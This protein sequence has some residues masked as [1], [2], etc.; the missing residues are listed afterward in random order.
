MDQNKFRRHLAEATKQLID[1][2]QSLC[3]ND[4]SDAFRYTI[5]PSS[6][7]LKKDVEHLNEFEISVLKTWNKY[8]NQS[9]TAYQTVELLHHK[10]KVPLWIDMSVYEANSDLTI[11]DLFCS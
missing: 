8:E 11:I 6:R 10:N 3:F 2:T 9:L 7:T 5:T 1:F 4:S